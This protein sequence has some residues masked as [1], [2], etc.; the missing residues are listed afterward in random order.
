MSS[1]SAPSSN[2][3][4]HFLRHEACFIA[5]RRELEHANELAVTV[6][7]PER[8]AQAPCVFA[9]HRV[10]ATQDA[11]RAAVVLLETDQLRALVAVTEPEDLIHV[12]AA[13]SVDRLVVVADDAKLGLDRPNDRPTRC[14]GLV[15]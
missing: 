13:P 9:N 12:R 5:L 1:G 10:R 11:H 2:R 15:S 7:A 14:T 8:L 6:V 3:L 4:P